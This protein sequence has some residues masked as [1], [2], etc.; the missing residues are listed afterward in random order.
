MNVTRPERTSPI[1]DEEKP[2]V[3]LVFVDGLGVGDDDPAR[4][5]LFDDS[6]RI[7]SCLQGGR[8]VKE[9]FPY[10]DFC[11]EIDASLGI[12]GIP[13]SATG[14]TAL[15][16]GVN[17][18]AVLGRHLTGLP[19]RRLRR[20]IADES[21]FVKLRR[22][23]LL[24][25]FA[26][27]FTPEFHRFLQAERLSV[28]TWATLA[29][30]RPLPPISDIPLKQAVYQEFTNLFLRVR[31]HELPLWSP[32]QAGEVLAGLATRQP[33]LL[34][35]YFM[36]DLAGHSRDKEFAGLIARALDGFLEAFLKAIDLD[37]TL[38]VLTSDHGNIE[39]IST[40]THTRHPVPLMVWG[41]RSGEYFAG[42]KSLT[43]ITPAIIK[44]FDQTSRND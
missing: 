43:D 6:L 31:G 9:G 30:E 19:N 15:L 34:Y 11:R 17:A 27:A 2:R 18:A 4:N 22:R 23:G 39:D 41:P 1:F 24:G 10:P 26:N 38:V 8:S 33:F 25:N 40:K 44:I 12:E 7:L 20:I 32:A 3:V 14:Q 42:V 37:R 13:Q 36:T 28:T 16:T 21:I 29:G 35:E 5:P